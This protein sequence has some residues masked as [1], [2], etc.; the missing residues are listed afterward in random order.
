MNKQDKLSED[1]RYGEFWSGDIKLGLKSIEPPTTLLNKIILMAEELQIVRDY[2]ESPIIITSAYRTP[3][4]NKK[5]GGVKNSYH[6]QCRACDIK[7]IGM[8][9]Q[10]LAIYVAKLTEFRGYGI[11]LHKG[12]LHI[13]MRSH[14]MIFRY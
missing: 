12:F 6:I 3:E 11:N 9:L 2:I 1:F 8:P 5:V 4:Y 13:D 14:L 10:D 7:V